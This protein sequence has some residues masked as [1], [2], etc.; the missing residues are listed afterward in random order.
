MW[1][2]ATPAVFS[3]RVSGEKWGRSS[4]FRCFARVQNQPSRETQPQGSAQL[5][6]TTEVNGTVNRRVN[7]VFH[8]P[9]TFP[10]CKYRSRLFEIVEPHTI[11]R[12]RKGKTSTEKFVF[13]KEVC[14]AMRE[15]QSG[16]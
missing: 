16:E 4:P 13:F 9:F 2:G 1:A 3:P 12:P 5:P 8:A 7:R 15:P 11:K 14:D 6:F 10:H